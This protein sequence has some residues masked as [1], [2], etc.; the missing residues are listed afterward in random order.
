MPDAPSSPKAEAARA[1]IIAAMIR[2]LDAAGYAGASIGQVQED[3]GVSRGALT[4]HFPTK[5]ALTAATARRLLDA[6][7]RTVEG[8]AE[9]A[10]T[11]TPA[12][13]TILAAVVA[14]AAP[15]VQAIAPLA[16]PPRPSVFPFISPAPRAPAAPPAPGSPL[17]T[18]A[19]AL[20]PAARG[21]CSSSWTSTSG[22]K[23]SVSCPSG[24]ARTRCHL[25]PASSPSRDLGATSP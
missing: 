12:T 6:A 10:P 21:S 19:P 18:T 25:Q 24:G 20:R 8:R 15:A 11:A 14:V 4:H 17:T 5:Q 22:A 3:A 2:R 7:L 1:R 13:T 9:A 23:W 16:G